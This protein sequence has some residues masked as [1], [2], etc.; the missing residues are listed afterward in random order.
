MANKY[1]KIEYSITFKA[2]SFMISYHGTNFLG[3]N[4]VKYIL[5]HDTSL[6]A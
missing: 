5:C 1:E 2:R 6:F 4:V 3:T